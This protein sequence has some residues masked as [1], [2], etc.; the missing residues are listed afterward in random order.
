MSMPPLA[1]WEYNYQPDPT[2]QEAELAQY[3]VPQD[4]LAQ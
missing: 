4:W 3:L 1:R 2:S